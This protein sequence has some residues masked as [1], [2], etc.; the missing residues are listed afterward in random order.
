ML[1][2]DLVRCPFPRPKSSR[3]TRPE[4]HSRQWQRT[5]FYRSLQDGA[6]GQGCSLFLVPRGGGKAACAHSHVDGPL[7]FSRRAWARCVHASWPPASLFPISQR[8]EAPVA[9]S[10]NSPSAL[11]ARHFTPT[12]QACSQSNTSRGQEVGVTPAFQHLN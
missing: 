6:E 5:C 1:L 10:G 3:H 4:S 11:S 12:H 2:W 8:L 9:L 7:P